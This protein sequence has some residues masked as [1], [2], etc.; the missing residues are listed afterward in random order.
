[1]KVINYYDAWKNQHKKNAFPI[2]DEQKYLDDRYYEVAKL[3]FCDA[4]LL[5][6]RISSFDK[7]IFFEKIKHDS[8]VVLGLS[9]SNKNAMQKHSEDVYL[10]W[11]KM[12]SK[13]PAVIILQQQGRYNG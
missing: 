8:T 11:K 12:T 13:N 6:R 3:E 2:F 9:S 7:K 1:M 4:R 10:N 5:F